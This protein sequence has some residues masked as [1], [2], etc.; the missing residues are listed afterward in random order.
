[1]HL[2]LPQPR[3][4]A[5]VSASDRVQ[6]L[7]TARSRRMMRRYEVAYLNSRSELVE[8]TRLAPAV[9]AF[10]DSF[11][12]FARGTL[13]QTARGP[14]AVEDLLP[15][16]TVITAEFGSQPILWRG[17]MTVIP[18]PDRQHRAAS[19]LVRIA[20]DSMGFARPQSD[21]VLGPGARLYHRHPGLERLTGQIG[22]VFPVR[23]FIDGVSI[24]EVSPA[25]AVQVFHLGFSQHHRITA[26]GLEAETQ[27][28]DSAHALGLRG[29][30]LALYLGLFP[31]MP[32]MEAFGRLNYPR[33]RMSD[34]DLIEVA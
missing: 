4:R 34:L 11:S 3:Q 5:A 27:H 13:I 9:P 7:E 26:D 33:M 25:S 28:P 32:G 29:E 1:M 30:M 17:S 22:A 31:H 21:L 18:D 23:D 12:A 8:V 20:P 6:P 10:E 19:S 16:D 24:I 15:G 2:P 14:A